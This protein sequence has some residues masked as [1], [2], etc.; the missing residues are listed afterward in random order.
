MSNLYHAN[1]RCTDPRPARQRGAITFGAADDT[2][3]A[4]I[5]TQL[6]TY[7]PAQLTSLTKKLS[8]DV[9]V[10][11]YPLG[12]RCTVQAILGDSVGNVWRATIRNVNFTGL[13]G[14][15]LEAAVTAFFMGTGYTDTQYNINALSAPPVLPNSGNP[16]SYVAD[17]RIITKR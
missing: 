2:A 15:N 13:A 14:S 4:A 7:T 9:G 1:L 16:V 5:A 12:T 11:S 3:A 17:V 6:Q 8:G 10:E